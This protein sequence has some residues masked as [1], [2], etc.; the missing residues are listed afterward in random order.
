MIPAVSNGTPSSAD[1]LFQLS[2][3][4]RLVRPP[5]MHV[6]CSGSVPRDRSKENRRPVERGGGDVALRGPERPEEGESGVD[7]GAAVDWQSKAAERPLC[8]RQALLPQAAKDE[9]AN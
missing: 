1:R 4:R 7:D 9:A 5:A 8:V 3:E 6:I 2:D